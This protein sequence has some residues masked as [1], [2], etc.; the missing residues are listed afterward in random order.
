MDKILNIPYFSA[1]QKKSFFVCLFVLQKRERNFTFYMNT[2]KD[3][4]TVLDQTATASTDPK[5][6]FDNIYAV[7]L[8]YTEHKKSTATNI[9]QKLNKAAR[10][11]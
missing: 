2:A 4:C 7:L 10:L 3:I 11:S 8:K 9:S 1:Q 6:I 5:I